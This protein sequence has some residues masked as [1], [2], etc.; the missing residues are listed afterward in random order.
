M[1]AECAEGGVIRAVLRCAVLLVQ[2]GTRRQPSCP[3]PLPSGQY[4]NWTVCPSPL[5]L[6]RG[7]HG[8]NGP[9]NCPQAFRW[10]M[11]VWNCRGHVNSTRDFGAQWACGRESGAV[12]SV[13][14]VS[15]PKKGQRRCQW[16][17]WG[18]RNTCWVAACHLG[19]VRAEAAPRA[20]FTYERIQKHTTHFA[21]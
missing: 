18:H 14:G 19:R 17:L 4:T 12:Y 16:V 5:C 3:S 20:R 15:G 8:P 7:P 21:F 6:F 9:A 13:L 10:H 1:P 11:M 2:A